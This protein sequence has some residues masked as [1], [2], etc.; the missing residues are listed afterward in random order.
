M[1]ELIL[2]VKQFDQFYYLVISFEFAIGFPSKYY[3]LE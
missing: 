1:L 2:K 3:R